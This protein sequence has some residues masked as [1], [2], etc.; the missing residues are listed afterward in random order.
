MYT[1]RVDDNYHYMDESER[2]TL[3]EY[4]TW[5]EAVAAAKKLVDD[6]LSENYKPGMIAGDLYVCYTMFGED[7]FIVGDRPESK[8]AFSGWDYAKARCEDLCRR[9]P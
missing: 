4:E 7:P 2:F 5:D 6:F 3:G 1:V 8:E 9:A